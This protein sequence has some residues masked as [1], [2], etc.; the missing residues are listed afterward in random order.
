MIHRT[1]LS[2]ERFIAY[3]LARG[4][5][6]VAVVA[7]HWVG[8]PAPGAKKRKRKNTIF[9][10]FWQNET[11]Q[12]GD[13]SG[14]HVFVTFVTRIFLSP[15]GLSKSVGRDCRLARRFAGSERSAVTGDVLVNRYK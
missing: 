6:K 3:L 12:G 5:V 9:L 1:W 10:L 15:R 4:N 14:K 13:L 2:I 7:S 8:F 11:D